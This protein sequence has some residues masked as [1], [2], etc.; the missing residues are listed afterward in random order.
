MILIIQIQQRPKRE[1]NH[2]VIDVVTRL[3]N[4]R[5]NKSSTT[6]LKPAR[7]CVQ[8]GIRCSTATEHRRNI[9]EKRFNFFRFESNGRNEN[10]SIPRVR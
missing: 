6:S 9:Q 3:Y 4:Y 1:S 2:S 7:V 5:Y 10:S 8:R